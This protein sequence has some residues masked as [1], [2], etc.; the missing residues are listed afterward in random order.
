M[1][2][3]PLD[4]RKIQKAIDEMYR[5]LEVEEMNGKGENP[6]QEAMDNYKQ[7]LFFLS[8]PLAK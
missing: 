4:L 7:A 2:R 1:V 8:A 3:D 5:K 6:M